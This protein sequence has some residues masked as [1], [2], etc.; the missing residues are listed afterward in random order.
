MP[1]PVA[2]VDLNPNYINSDVIMLREQQTL[3]DFRNLTTT[4][5]GRPNVAVSQYHGGQ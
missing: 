1:I 3:L 4:T 2:V 5:I